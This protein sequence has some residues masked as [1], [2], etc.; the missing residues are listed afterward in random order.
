MN[1]TA[2]RVKAAKRG[3]EYGDNMH[4]TA[5]L[6]VISQVAPNMAPGSGERLSG[7][8]DQSERR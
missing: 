4:T 2:R 3:K 1:C 7:N 6:T 5:G 8:A